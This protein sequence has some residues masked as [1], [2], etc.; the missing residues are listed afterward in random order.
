MR[1][2]NTHHCSK[3]KES[4]YDG[5]GVA[6]CPCARIV[7][8]ATNGSSLYILEQIKI[9]SRVTFM[10]L[11]KIFVMLEVFVLH[12]RPLGTISHEI[13]FVGP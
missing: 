3:A 8:Q 2:R 6:R 11:S 10:T 5:F 4:S 9:Y 12:I 1:N 7:S 13:P